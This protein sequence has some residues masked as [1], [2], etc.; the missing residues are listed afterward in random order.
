MQPFQIVPPNLTR[1]RVKIGLRRAA[2]EQ[3]I[4]GKQEVN[5][6]F[7]MLV[8][9]GDRDVGCFPQV[10]KAA[11]IL[12]YRFHTVVIALR[13]GTR[14]SQSGVDAALPGARC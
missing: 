12:Q 3:G 9:V 13:P 6:A 14:A 4:A 5:Y 2:A 8:V 11:T 10:G 7:G 1:S